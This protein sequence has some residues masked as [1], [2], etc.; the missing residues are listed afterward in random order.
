MKAKKL[1]HKVWVLRLHS[2]KLNFWKVNID[3][4]FHQWV[5]AAKLEE[6]LPDLMLVEP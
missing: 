4:G 3:A 5:M 6:G 2:Q 1:A